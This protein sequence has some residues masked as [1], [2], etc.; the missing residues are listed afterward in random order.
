MTTATAAIDITTAKTADSEMKIQAHLVPDKVALAT[1]TPDLLKEL[2]FVSTY[3]DTDPKSSSPQQHGYQRDPMEERFMGIGKYYANNGHQY[4]IPPII[5]SVRVE[6]HAERVKFDQL[7]NAGDIAGIHAEFDKSVFSIVDGQHRMGGLAWAW[8]NVPDFN[9]Q[10][11]VMLFYGLGY[12]EEAGLFD[13][14]NT[15]QRKL[16][17]ALIEATKVHVESGTVSHAQAVR[18]ISFAVAQDGSSVWYGKIN[19]TGARDPERSVTYEG[20]RR[21]TSQMFPDRIL[22]RLAARNLAPAE[23]AKRYWSLV[24]KASSPAWNEKPRLVKTAEGTTVEE[25]VHY[26]LKDLVGVASLAKL[27]ENILNTS[28]DRSSSADEFYTVMTDL[29]STLSV[30]DWEKGSNNP[31]MA[32]QA[33]FAGQKDLYEILYNLVYLGVSPGEAVHP[34]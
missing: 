22:S 5:A 14:I 13:D 27:G 8:E 24:A 2:A 31:W 11:P 19:M 7:F 29:V 26:R 6:T 32:S 16:P 21:S 15:N 4:L 3:S 34:E 1:L 9:A 18:E 20:L 23:V 28:L 25:K 17:K 30:V 33:G 12:A 10:V